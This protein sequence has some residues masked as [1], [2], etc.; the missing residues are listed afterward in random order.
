MDSICLVFDFTFYSPF[1][2]VLDLML[3]AYKSL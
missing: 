2:I 1:L 3:T